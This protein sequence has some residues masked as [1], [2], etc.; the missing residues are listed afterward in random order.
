M[1]LISLE[2]S[3]LKRIVGCEGGGKTFSKDGKDGKDDVNPE[4]PSILIKDLLC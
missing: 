1:N 3:G 2:S 4:G